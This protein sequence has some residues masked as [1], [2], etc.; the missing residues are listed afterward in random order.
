M[1]GVPSVWTHSW[2]QI[3]SSLCASFALSPPAWFHTAP[4]GK[5][6]DCKKTPETGTCFCSSFSQC[7][8]LSD[9]ILPRSLASPVRNA[10]ELS[11]GLG[12]TVLAPTAFRCHRC[13]AHR[14]ESESD[15]PQPIDVTSHSGPHRM[16]GPPPPNPG[17]RISE[18]VGPSAQGMSCLQVGLIQVIQ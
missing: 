10:R 17:K 12:D 16:F 11:S 2:S 13:P 4:I 18:N 7:E 14:K 9:G 3:R 15:V 1:G 5:S 8:T 6:S